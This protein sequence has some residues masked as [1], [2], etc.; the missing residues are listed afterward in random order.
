MRHGSKRFLDRTV[1]SQDEPLATFLEM[2]GISKRFGGVHALRG[3]DLALEVG[4]VPCLVCQHGSGKST[5][6][7]I[8][9]GVES[10][11]PGGRIAISGEEYP[12]LNPV[13]ST[14]CGI[15]VIYQ[16]LSLF[17]NLT[18]AENIAM[19]HHLGGVHTVNWASMRATAI[20]TM[21]QVG[22]ELDLDAKVA[23]LSIAGRQ[24]VA[25]C[26]ALAADAKLLIMD[27]P[28]A[29]LTRHEVNTLI[30]LVSDL[31]R[32][33]ICV[34]FV[35]HRLDEVLEIAERVTVLR[36]GAKVGTFAAE[37]IDDRKLSH[38]ITGKTFEYQVQAGGLAA[39]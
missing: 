24:L 17:P 38:L 14:H 8:I 2:S 5:L 29:S 3:V 28:T 37:T 4:E 16:D 33:G 9:S 22:I 25:I 36:D 13:Y 26:R 27:E 34:V 39:S 11:E 19:A 15:Q 18:V 1:S 7:K 31:K 23:D 35:S 21:A 20:A 6:I 10:P 32:S 30:E 12:K